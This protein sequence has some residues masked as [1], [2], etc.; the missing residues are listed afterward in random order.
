VQIGERATRTDSTGRFLLTELEAG[1]QEILYNGYTAST[2]GHLYAMCENGVNIAPGLTN[3]LPYTVWLPAID[4]RH[5]TSIPVPTTREVVATN[6]VM[7]GLEVHIP[8]GVRLLTHHGT[9]LSTLTLTP[10]PV[11]RAPFPVPEGTQFLFTPQGHGAEVQSVDGRQSV[12]IRITYPN[13]TR[14]PAGTGVTLW[15]HNAEKGWYAYG[16]G[17]VTKDGKQIVPNAG[18]GLQRLNCIGIALDGPPPPTDGP[19]P[20]GGEMVDDPVDLGT[21]LFVYS[22]TDIRL[23]D[24][25]QIEL[26]RTYRQNDTV[27]RAF[28]IGAT[29][30]YNIYLVGDPNATYADLVLPTG[31]R[32]R[33]N[34]TSPGTGPTGAV[35]EHTGSQSVYYK[36][37]L[38]YLDYHWYLKFT[39][40]TVYDFQGLN[41]AL[42]GPPFIGLRS[43]RD[44]LGNQLTITRDYEGKITRM[45]SP[46]NRWLEFT[47]DGSDRITQLKDNIGRTVG[48]TYDASGRLWKATDP[49]NGVTEYSYDAAHRMTTIKDAR[50]ILYLT[51]EYDANGRIIK[52]TQADNTF[53]LFNYTLNANGK[54]AQTD[55]TDARGNVRR[56]VFNTDGYSVTDIY[57]LGKPEQQTYIY[58]RQPGTNLI[59]S[60]TDNLGRKMAYTYTPAGNLASVTNLAGTAQALTATF[61]YEPTFNQIETITDPLNHVTRTSYDAQ[62]N[63]TSVTDALNHQTTFT[64]NAAGQVLTV[65]DPLQHTVQYT[66][67]AGELSE[68]RDPLGYTIK[69]FHDGAGRVVSHTDQLGNITR[70]EF[71]K[72]NHVTKV[73]NVLQGTTAF[74]Y[75]ANGNLLHMTDARS[76]VTGFTYNNMDRLE[77]R[78]D[79]LQGA[80]SVERYEYDG[81]GNLSKITDRRGKVTTYSYDSLNRV[82]STQ[83]GVGTASQTGITYVFDGANRLTSVTDSLTGAISYGYDSYDRLTSE[84]TPL[85]SV[86]YGY[87]NGGRR[88]SM[89]V[90]G[91]PGVTYGYDDGNRLTSIT[92]GGAS[93]LLQYDDANRRSVMTLPNGVIATYSYD[94][95][96]ELTGIT[97]EKGAVLVGNLTYEYDAAGRRTKM[98]GNLARI[99]YPQ[100][101][102][103]ATYNAANQLTQKGTTTLSYDA[104]GN[105]T[106]DG[107]NTY[108]W[109]DRNQLAAISGGV[110]A[111]FTY[112]AFGRRINKSV[113]GQATGYLYDGAGAVQE[114][115]GTTPVA[116]LLTGGV[117]EVFS[118]NDAAGTRTLLTD[119]LGSTVAL[120][121]SSGA[122]QTQYSYDAFGGGDATGA[123][124][125]NT[126]QYTGR[127]N[128]GTGLYFNRAR[129]YSPALQRFISEDP[130]GFAAGDANLY[131]YVG[132]DPVNSID[133]SGLQ[134]ERRWVELGDGWRG[135]ID[136]FGSGQRFEIHVYRPNGDEA[137]IVSGRLGWIGKHGNAGVRPGGVPEGVMDT[138]NGVNV[139][140]LR[141]TGG[142][143]PKGTENLRGGRYVLPGRSFYGV[144][145]LQIL[146]I[147]PVILEEDL[148]WKELEAR[149]GKHGLTPQ[150]QFFIDSERLGHPQFYMTPIGP[151]PNPHYMG[152][153]NPFNKA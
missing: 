21:G 142:M 128:D 93:V 133:P 76:K 60:S 57:G 12:G 106:N 26:T 121:D 71:D 27:S 5:A 74:D 42:F 39:N 40:G 91:Q 120:T 53:F 43:V 32:V 113:N 81:N 14:L 87:D 65:T 104:N 102:S 83:Y 112:D 136:R 134:S 41:S 150:E 45:A 24:V 36:S 15:D 92:Q 33:Y 139:D 149:A 147:L 114:L 151:M 118:R 54:V 108:T 144:A 101:F 28:G 73:T 132:N 61:T 47:Y 4:T 90:L 115:S 69:R 109:N 3:I 152:Q 153:R 129:Y 84:T 135:G 64:Y 30:S 137:G 63:A 99:A 44:R 6:P 98:G 52:Q 50:Q 126:S 119:A 51:N 95:A 70:Y 143:G 18:V 10:I 79:A 59:L 116:N 7:P 56:V 96:S 138:L 77:T 48:Y 78:T 68:I 11:D 124:S 103:S 111:T 13:L 19:T 20:D 25:M 62:G 2:P 100:A 105:L 127:E 94:N 75:D 34:R 67:D 23:P 17:T 29:H 88:E 46:N 141:R 58:E 123:L 146:S 82:T 97:Y 9:Y 37:T 22:K 122:M 8:A 16:K 66:Y 80:T 38:T 1:P 85:G 86:G 140:M 148:A 130:I 49:G 31:G 55:Y 131:A 107:V 145:A 72:M 117:D 35:M 125:S 89:T 110:A